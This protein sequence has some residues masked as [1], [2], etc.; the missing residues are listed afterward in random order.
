MKWVDG[1]RL[2]GGSPTD[3]CVCVCVCARAPSY[4]LNES[5]SPFPLTFASSLIHRPCSRVHSRSSLT[6]AGSLMFFQLFRCYSEAACHALEV[7]YVFHNSEYFTAT[8][9]VFSEAIVDYWTDF[10]SGS[11][12]VGPGP[13]NGAGA[14]RCL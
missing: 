5:L 6:F 3:L 1:G 10:A 11:C 8:E 7:P 9:D 2:W 12:S 14:D 13:R 4:G